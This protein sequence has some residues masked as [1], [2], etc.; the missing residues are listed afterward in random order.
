MAILA[1]GQNRKLI[2][3]NGPR[4]SGKDTAALRCVETF[5]AFHFKMSGPIKAALRAMFD[6][7]E[8]EVNYLESIKTVNSSL[9]F[10]TSYVDAQISFSEDWAKSFFGTQVFGLL[11]ARC[12]RNAFRR[13]PAQAVFVCSDSGFAHEAL[14]LVDIFGPANILLV[15]VF[16]DGK[17]FEGD[18]RSYIHLNNVASISVTNR[19]I[20]S[21]R[22]EIDDVV[23]TFLSDEQCPV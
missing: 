21:Y 19:T 8:D 14:P 22:Q 23:A 12:I 10:D 13:Y 1:P 16:R 17:T 2:L 4:H 6:L 5:D 7:H 3:F 11:A 18:S 9:L 15:R 20:D